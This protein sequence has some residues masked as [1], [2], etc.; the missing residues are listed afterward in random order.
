MKNISL[1]ETIPELRQRQKVSYSFYNM[2]YDND[3]K[4]GQGDHSRTCTYSQPQL[5]GIKCKN[6]KQKINKVN[7]AVYW[8]IN[9]YVY[10]YIYV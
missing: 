6:P 1:N 3:P 10:K 4:T 9:L 7:L 5:L 8:Q 2:I